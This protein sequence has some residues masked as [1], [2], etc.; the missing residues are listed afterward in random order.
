MAHD[1]RE[2]RDKAMLD[3][4]PSPEVQ[5]DARLEPRRVWGSAIPSPVAA[6]NAPQPDE[7]YELA[8]YLADAEALDVDGFTLKH[9]GAFLLMGKDSE[10]GLQFLDKL[11]DARA[12]SRGV[13]GFL[14][15]LATSGSL[16]VTS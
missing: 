15:T 14:E 10:A 16:E 2:I 7:A 8:H 13:E 5:A 3:S 4:R 12:T 1:T 9:G 6:M 11:S